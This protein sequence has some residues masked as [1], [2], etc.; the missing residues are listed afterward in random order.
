MKK[1]FSVFFLLLVL[2]VSLFFSAAT[3]ECVSH[4]WGSWITTKQATCLVEGSRIR[5]CQVCNAAQP[6]AVATLP[7][8]YSPATCVSLSRC[9][10]G[11]NRTQGTY[12][13]H[14]YA[15]ATCVT[16]ATCTV[17]G[18]QT[19]S[20]ASH[21]FPSTLCTI[22]PVCSVCNTASN[23][24]GSQ[25]DYSFATCME[26]SICSRCHATKPGEHNWI[27]SGNKRT[28]TYCGVGQLLGYEEPHM[29]E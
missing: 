29:H 3:S 14:N 9:L 17:C 28:C 1:R 18:H 21:S 19:G 11:C 26:T 2:L 4:S 5:Y 24:Y 7:H 22:H 15:A 12:A 25:H 23:G 13:S 20:L 6:Q 8:Y 16:K 10:N 27:I